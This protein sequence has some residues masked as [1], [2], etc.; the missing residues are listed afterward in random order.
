[1]SLTHPFS[2]TFVSD[3]PTISDLFDEKYWDLE[4]HDLLEACSNVNI[5]ITTEE[6][7]LLEEN[8]RIQ[9]QGSSFYRNRTDRVGGEQL[10]K[11]IL[12]IL[13][14]IQHSVHGHK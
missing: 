4:Y 7:K 5:Q 10:V 2:G 1:M 6:R 11:Q 14:P 13:T 12:Q 8:I 3:I 9:S